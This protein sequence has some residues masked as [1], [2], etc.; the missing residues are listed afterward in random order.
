MDIAISPGTTGFIAKLLIKDSVI[1]AYKPAIVAANLNIAY[2]RDDDGNAS[3]TT[4]SL[5]IGTRGTWSSGGFI[6]KDATNS[7]GEYEFGIPNAALLPGSKTV[8]FTIKDSGSH[9]IETLKYEIQL[10]PIL[11]QLADGV[12]HGG[13]TAILSIKQLNIINPDTSPVV[14]AC[15][16]TN[17]AV[18]ISSTGANAAGIYCHAGLAG[19]FLE[20]SFSGLFCLSTDSG[21]GVNIQGATFGTD[22]LGGTDGGLR[23]NGRLADS[24][25]LTSDSQSALHLSGGGS[26]LKISGLDAEA[27][28]IST[29]IDVTGADAIKI[30][31]NGVDKHDIYLAG[32]GDILGNL[33]GTIDGLTP[34]G[35]T[36]L[37]TVDSTKTYTD[38]IAGSPIKEIINLI[39]NQIIT[40]DYAVASSPFTLSQALYE[41]CQTLEERTIT[42]STLIIKKRDG[43]T[44]AFNINLDS[45]TPT[46][47]SRS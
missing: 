40:E 4:V 1:N 45:P 22:I 47:Q 46:T 26:G 9:N 25:Y 39:F 13:S 44:E 12:V 6:E 35:L 27:I 3:S 34:T 8:V 2:S 20:G 14:I 38:A 18:D 5:S 28:H 7:P 16:G 21:P 19:I 43:T 29:G 36:T 15:T 33:T 23:I 30:I 32:S 17:H 10:A 24:V 31:A 42:G 41:I 37:F 11:S